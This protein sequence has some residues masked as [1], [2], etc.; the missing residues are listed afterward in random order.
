MKIMATKANVAFHT[1][2]VTATTSAKLTTP[3]SKARRAPPAADQPMLSPF[4]C[5]ITKINVKAKIRKALQI[6]NMI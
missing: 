1:I 3:H 4:G 6:A 2:P 5:Q